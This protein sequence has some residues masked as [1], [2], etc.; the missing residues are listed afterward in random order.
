MKNTI[1]LDLNASGQ[2][3]FVG[4]ALP[5]LWIGGETCYGCVPDK[6]VQTLRNMCDRILK[7]RGPKRKASKC[8]SG[9]PTPT[10]PAFARARLT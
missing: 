6:D 3:H 9:D 8:S 7:T 2:I 10:I 4:G 5:Y 1:K